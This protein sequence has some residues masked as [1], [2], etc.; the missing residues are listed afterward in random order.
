[1][2]AHTYA[3]RMHTHTHTYTHAHAY[4]HTHTHTCTHTRIHTHI[5]TDTGNTLAISAKR[6]LF[7]GEEGCR[8]NVG[9]SSGHMVVHAPTTI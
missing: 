3:V 7:E 8:V 1:M 2:C 6:P 4:I 9:G 5:H